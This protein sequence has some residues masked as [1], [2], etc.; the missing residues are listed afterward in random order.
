[1]DHRH[2]KPIDR[3][4][5]RSHPAAGLQHPEALITKYMFLTLE[6]DSLSEIEKRSAVE[7]R[8]L[9]MTS[10]FNTDFV[11]GLGPSPLAQMLTCL[12]YGDYVS[13]YLAMAY[14]L[15]PTV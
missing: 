2:F 1:M 14:G 3:P 12:H 7:T 11:R 13:F 4:G 6:C 8:T 9:F 15:D 5:R 10:G